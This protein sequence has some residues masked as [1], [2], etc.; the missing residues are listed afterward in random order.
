MKTKIIRFNADR[1]DWFSIKNATEQS[2][3]VYIYDEIGFWGTEA[4]VF[5]KQIAGLE[6]EE[7]NLHLNSPGGSVFQGQAIYTALKNHPA[8]VNVFIDG[9][10]ASIASIIAMAGDSIEIAHGAMIMIH[11]PYSC[12]CG[13]AED[14]RK[15]ADLLDTMEDTLV[16]TYVARTGGDVDQIADW[17]DDETWFTADEAVEHGF[18]DTKGEAKKAAASLTR[19]DLSLFDNPPDDP[20]DPEDTNQKVTPLSLMLRKQALIEL[21]TN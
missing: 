20:E 6:V 9:L 5:V 12:M 15:E 7:L 18:A 3:D 2:A 4:E 19:W 11:K 8:R 16:E 14:L 17:V 1:K 10:A 21:T 13:D